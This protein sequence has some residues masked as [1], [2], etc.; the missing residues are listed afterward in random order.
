MKPIELSAKLPAALQPDLE[1]LFFFNPHQP[2]SREGIIATVA[3]MGTP[4]IMQSGDSVWIGVPSGNTQCLFA[5][6]TQDNKQRPVGVVL[7]SRPDPSVIWISHLAI[8]PDRV[9]G[10]QEQ[11]I[12]L[13]CFLVEKVREIACRIKGVTRIQLPY[14]RD[15]F[16]PVRPLGRGLL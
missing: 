1:A 14:Q 9:G 6:E 13:G 2:K 4:V 12:G 15:R 7:Y 10:R 16:L 11:G 3:K 5:C 8:D